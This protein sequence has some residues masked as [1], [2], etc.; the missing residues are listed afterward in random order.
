MTVGVPPP[1]GRL[2]EMPSHTNTHISGNGCAEPTAGVP[3]PKA[4]NEANAASITAAVR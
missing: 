2:P 1:K 3:T 4:A